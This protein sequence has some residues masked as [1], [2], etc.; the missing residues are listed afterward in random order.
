MG[1]EMDDVC[2]TSLLFAD[3]QVVLAS[4]EG[5]IDYMFR[6]LIEEYEKWGLKVN[7]D[8]TEYLKI[9]EEQEDQELQIRKVKRG[10]EFKYLGS[11]ISGEGTS[12]SDIQHR[13][14]QGQKSIRL[15]NSLLWSKNIR[16]ET[17]MTIYKTIVE[18]IM[19]YGSENWQLTSKDRRSIGATEMD[20]L[21][22][23]C[24]VSRLE[25]I[26]NEEIRRKT[27]RVYSTVDTIETKQLMWYGHVMRMEDTRWPK[28]ALNYT[29]SNRRR[30]GRPRV[31]WRQNVEECMR[32][33]AID[34]ED[35][36]DRK[37]WRSKC[38]MRQRL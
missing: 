12:R 9:G 35:W 29:P 34:T 18:P 2:L 16:L 13:M 14:V 27:N 10:K 24:R 30:R 23:A 38:G 26:R 19:T 17:K 36:K 21:R 28:R 6:K 5:D 4:D 33:R 25:H 32:D 3:D 8:K 37:R 22:R 15:L 31:S 11:I 20:F 1:I 7:M